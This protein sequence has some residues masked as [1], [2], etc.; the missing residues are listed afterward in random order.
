[1]SAEA[2]NERRV[3]VAVDEGDES[4]Y[5]LSWS[6]ENLAFGNSKD[7][8]ILLYV[9][10]P[11]ATPK[12]QED[13]P[14]TAG[15]LISSDI[16]A[17]IERY[18]REVANCVLQKAKKLCKDLQHVKVETRVEN[19]DPREV[20]CEMSEKLNVDVLVMGTHGYGA[21]QRAFLGSVSNYCSQNVKCPVLIVKKPKSSS[22][23]AD[24]AD[25][26]ADFVL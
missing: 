26:Y 5:A 24:A 13:D 22:A 1:M 10:P 12:I 15:H 20:I 8:L 23:A 11:H 17:A 6:L 19:G 9:K 7:T 2:K 16:S 14:E 3:L 25:K 21:V 4:M 18:S